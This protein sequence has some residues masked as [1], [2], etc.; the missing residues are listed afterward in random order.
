MEEHPEYPW[1]QRIY[2]FRKMDRC[3]WP[4]IIGTYSGS[5][6]DTGR[7][8]SWECGNITLA[9]IEAQ[10]PWIDAQSVDDSLIWDG[11]S[12][13]PNLTL[14]FIDKYIDKPWNY[15][16]LATNRL[17]HAKKQFCQEYLAA[18]TIQ[19]AY[20]RAKYIPLY[21]YCRKLH[22]QFYDSLTQ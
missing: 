5:D 17:T 4:P 8:Y 22:M 19:Q 9:Y 13:N 7:P 14:D 1:D 3:D 12:D 20:A 18:Y 16:I 11:I 15:E 10:M 2:Y 6:E 21:A